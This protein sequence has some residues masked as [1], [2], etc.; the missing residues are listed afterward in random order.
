MF[1]SATAPVSKRPDRIAHVVMHWLCALVILAQLALGWWMGTVP[2]LPPGLRAGWF[3]LHKSLGLVAAM[4]VV[5][6]M[7]RRDWRHR[8]DA[9]PRWQ[10]LAARANHALLLACI[11]VLP[12]SGYL[13]SS[14][15]RYPVL[16]FGHALPQ[17]AGDW[18]AG[19]QAM[20][21]LHEA[22]VWLLM[23]VLA[24]HI[25]AALWH[26]IKGHPSAARMGLASL[27]KAEP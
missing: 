5:I 2:K 7:L 16:F 13:G 26:W 9:M 19:K 8:P 11:V 12:V 21:L 1:V 18:P 15:T 3:N 20:S 27:R 10:Q 22:T 17:W 14:F 24:V 23:P 6:W 4:L 25:A